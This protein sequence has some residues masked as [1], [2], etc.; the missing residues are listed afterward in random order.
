[1]HGFLTKPVSL[2]D[3]RAAIERIASPATIDPIP[4]ASAGSLWS[5]KAATAFNN[6][7]AAAEY[8]RRSLRFC[9]VLPRLVAEYP[10]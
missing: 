3:L 9:R 1:M 6:Q 7:T 8:P 2:A 4:A 10:A 5:A